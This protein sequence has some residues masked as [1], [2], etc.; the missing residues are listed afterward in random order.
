MLSINELINVLLN[1]E[2]HKKNITSNE[3]PCLNERKWHYFLISSGSTFIVGMILTLLYNF[4]WYST[5]KIREWNRKRKDPDEY[6]ASLNN[7][8]QNEKISFATLF[9]MRAQLVISG[10]T[11]KGRI[12]VSNHFRK[13]QENHLINIYL[14][15]F[16]LYIQYWIFNYISYRRISVS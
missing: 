16:I 9:K 10:Q 11:V 8:H 15:K 14:D 4:I 7:T 1:F 13:M 6:Y 2:K 5:N 3:N 12:L